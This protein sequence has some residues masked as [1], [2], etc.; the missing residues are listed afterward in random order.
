VK[1][2]DIQKL[3][4]VRLCKEYHKRGLFITRD[5]GQ[6]IPAAEI[7]RA[8]KDVMSGKNPLTVLKQLRRVMIGLKG[9]PDI[10][11]LLDGLWVGIE[12]KTATGKQRPDQIKFQAAI[13]ARNGIYIVARSPDDAINHIE[14][15]LTARAAA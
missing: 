9:E 5:V 10:S 11:G 1:E 8:I 7:A 4:H 15:A 3:I 14:A 2:R 13:E 12:V 6:Y